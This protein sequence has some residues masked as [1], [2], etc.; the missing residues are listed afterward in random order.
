MSMDLFLDEFIA[1]E[2]LDGSFRELVSEAYRPIAERILLES[3][4]GA[5]SG[6]D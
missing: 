3:R 5:Y 6:G 4:K 2:R 1:N